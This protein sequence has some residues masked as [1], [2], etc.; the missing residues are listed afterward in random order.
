MSKRK[1]FWWGA[2]LV[3]LLC[4]VGAIY[5]QRTKQAAI[6]ADGHGKA[7]SVRV[8]TTTV[9][10]GSINPVL[11]SS[12]QVAAAR[13]VVFTAKTQGVV[14]SLPHRTGERVAAGQVL[15]VLESTNQELLAGKAR[16]Q[17]AAA[18]AAL[19][20]MEADLQRARELYRSGA[21]ARSELEQVELGW[22]NARAAY[23]AALKDTSLAGQAVAD[24]RMVAPFA[25]SIASS[26]VQEGEMVFPGR[27]LF[28]LV[29]DS[30]LKIRASLTAAQVGQV[31]TGMPAVFQASAL[32]GRSYTCTVTA[33]SS[34]A[35]PA[36]LAYEMEAAV[37]GEGAKDLRP[38]MFGHLE[39]RLG[40][41]RALLLPRTAV[42]SL[43]ETGLARVFVVRQGRAHLQQV[44]TTAGDSQHL[45]VLDGLGGGE[46]VVI[47]GQSRLSDGTPV[48]EGE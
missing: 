38:G 40:E 9:T 35:D 26:L 1:M 44:R 47:F 19:A 15:A 41:R 24:T 42:V 17:V 29:D 16:E 4:L 25:G 13:E 21:I 10:E 46:R 12:G 37:S 14:V 6:S 27:P 48:S 39:V 30:K 11:A 45:V 36:S 43:D 28:T 20:K 33:I 23:Q 32:P 7:S 34:K 3:L 31:R 22:Q 18:Y 2:V 8:K 5:H